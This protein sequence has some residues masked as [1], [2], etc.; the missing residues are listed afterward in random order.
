MSKYN[1]IYFIPGLATDKLIYKD[2]INE[3]DAP[4]EVIEFK[5]LENDDSLHDYAKKM[6]EEVDDSEP[7][8]IIGTSFGGILAME[9][10]KIKHPTK[11]V[12]ISSAKNREELSP[13]MRLKGASFFVSMV[14]DRIMKH[15]FNRG[16][17]ISTFVK[18]SYKSIY[19]QETKAM[20]AKSSG[21]FDK[22]VMKQVSDWDSDYEHQSLLHIHGDKDI[23]FPIKYIRNCYVIKGG[24]HPMIINRYKEIGKVITDFLHL[25]SNNNQ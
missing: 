16:F 8:V 1:K 17:H 23:V 12:I 11:I 2:L 3:L 20:V 5:L 22:W 7:F 6:C 18:K 14:P 24:G 19:N 9:M 25:P 4:C 15:I 13:I 10:A 21:G